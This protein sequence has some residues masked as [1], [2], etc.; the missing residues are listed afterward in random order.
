M[1]DLDK[2]PWEHTKH[3]LWIRAVWDLPCLDVSTYLVVVHNKKGHYDIYLRQRPL[4]EV[5]M[6]W[7]DCS[8]EKAQLIID[9][10]CEEDVLIKYCH[11]LIERGEAE[12]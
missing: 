8:K 10:H 9:K 2:L 1:P 12:D 4:A 7:V 3:L 6:S 5:L 11:D